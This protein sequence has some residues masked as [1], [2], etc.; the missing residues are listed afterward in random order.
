MSTSYKAIL[1]GLERGGVGISVRFRILMQQLLA[2]HLQSDGKSLE[3]TKQKGGKNFV[4]RFAKEGVNGLPEAGIEDVPGPSFVEIRM[5][6]A[7]VRYDG[8]YLAHLASSARSAGCKSVL[9]VVA[10]NYSQ[11]QKT[12]LEMLNKRWV[13][14][15]S[16]IELVVWGE[17]QLSALVDAYPDR[18]DEI[19]KGMGV[20]RLRSVVEQ[21]AKDWRQERD[22]RLA[23]LAGSYSKGELTLFLGAGVSIDAG[24]PDWTSLLDS[25]FVRFLTK[26]LSASDIRDEEIEEI[27]KRLKDVDDPSPLMVARHLRRGIVGDSSEATEKFRQQITE[28]LYQVSKKRRAIKSD[29]LS[30]LAHMTRPRRSGAK[31]NA[32]VTY[33]FDDLLEKQLNASGDLYQSIFREG[34]TASVEE[35]PIYHVHGFLPED[36]DGYDRLR[37][38]TLA[39]AEEGY[40]EIYSDSYHWSN[41]VQLN[42]LRD[43]S[44]LFVGLSLTD[45]NLRRLLEIAAR[46][47]TGRPHFA[48]MK[49]MDAKAFMHKNGRKIVKSRVGS[50]SQFL[51]NHHQVKEELFRELGVSIVWFEKHTEVPGLLERVEAATDG[52]GL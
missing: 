30:R 8:E 23:E 49:R 29:L 43:T 50:V 42:L 11:R 24:L 52:T 27:V 51:D 6:L 40:H 20:E 28:S 15:E 10:R 9:L 45:P 37:E 4:E 48:L 34:A 13:Q 44:C 16:T 17:D 21:P 1:D 36:R 14:M 38:S 2:I 3:T 26:E 22:D 12:R 35:L 19:V 31:V 7:S 5:G 33:N 32:V 39:F 25:L 46:R 18:V 47:T 41:L